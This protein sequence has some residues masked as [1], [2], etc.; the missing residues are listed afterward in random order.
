VAVAIRHC[1][2]VTLAAEINTPTLTLWVSEPLIPVTESVKDPVED[3]DEALAVSVAVAGVPE[4]GVTGLGR[5]TEIPE[6][7]DPSQE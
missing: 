2:V 1:G 7:A 6:G 5:L 4:V 3:E